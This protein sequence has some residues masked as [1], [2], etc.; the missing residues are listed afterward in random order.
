[1]EVNED[2]N[3]DQLNVLKREMTN[4]VVEALYPN[5]A[6][7]TDSSDSATDLFDVSI[8]GIK[9]GSDAPVDECTVQNDESTHCHMMEGG[10]SIYI[11]GLRR[12]LA[13][14]VINA[15]SPA[16]LVQAVIKSSMDSGELQN[17]V[18]GITSLSWVPLENQNITDRKDIIN[19]NDDGNQDNMLLYAIPLI[20]G[21]SFLIGGYA[22]IKHK[23]RLNNKS[24]GEGSESDG[25][26][27][28]LP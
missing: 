9:A 25:N 2:Y 12:F 16:L 5:C 23:E 18:T 4:I 17:T 3:E 14:S 22:V 11:D 10:I 15:T 6:T 8:V 19:I 27:E 7:V 21:L 20:G 13:D 26:F 28:E 1:M 24:S